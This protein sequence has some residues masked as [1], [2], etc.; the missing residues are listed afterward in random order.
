MGSGSLTIRGDDIAA[1]QPPNRTGS[2][3]ARVSS[4]AGRAL[5]AVLADRKLALPSI[6]LVLLVLF[7]VLGPVIWNHSPDTQNLIKSLES[8]SLSHPL[9]TDQLGRDVL[10]RV[11]D[12]ARI[13]LL[14]ATI[15]T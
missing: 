1:K 7:A 13:S 8:P 3:S 15:V 11:A 9:G 4:R 12:G 14:V 6:V 2:T 5:R 10:A